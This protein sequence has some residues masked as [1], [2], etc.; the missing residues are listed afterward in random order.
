MG[1]IWFYFAQL[2]NNM[3][4]FFAVII[5]SIISGKDKFDTVKNKK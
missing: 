2:N 1:W 5:L 3:L 4:R